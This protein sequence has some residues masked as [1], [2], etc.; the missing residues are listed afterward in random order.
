MD[1]FIGSTRD[2]K[3]GK[4]LTIETNGELIE[5]QYGNNASGEY[6]FIRKIIIKDIYVPLVIFY[7]GCFL[8]FKS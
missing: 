7:T 5:D 4:D 8:F 2:I 3:G 6:L 1:S